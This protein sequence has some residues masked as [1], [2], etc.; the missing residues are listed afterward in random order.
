MF[1]HSIS[2]YFSAVFIWGS[3]FFAIKFQ[4]GEVAP[5]LSIA[6]RFAI[7]SLILFG[8]SLFKGL[9]MRFNRKQ[10]LWMAFQGL[11]LFGLNYLV[12]YWA[13]SSLTSGLI[14]VIFSTIVLMNIANSIIFLR[15][16]A[17][18]LMIVG[19]LMGLAGI[20][21]IFAPEFTNFTASNN[22]LT[23]IGLSL[24]GTFIASL[25]NIISAHNQKQK[26]PVIQT[27]AYGM[28]YGAI[29]LLVAALFQGEPLNFDLSLA[30][31]LSLLYLALFGSVLA[32][33]SYL[34]LLG[35]IG[36]EKAAYTMVLFPLVA[37]GISTIFENYQWTLSSILGVS[38]VLLGNIIIILPKGFMRS[39]VAPGKN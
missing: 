27:N 33:G 9:P 20:G 23:G 11:F 17:S 25:G 28:A 35:R 37:L 22:S 19:A 1:T 32:F 26:M 4:L 3:T 2:L 29:I 15:K 18:M 6:Y 8:W 31:S 14:A 13:T 24:L 30:Y 10:H 16:S 21:L 5:E 39:I 7:A 34:T 12:I 36:P 38:L